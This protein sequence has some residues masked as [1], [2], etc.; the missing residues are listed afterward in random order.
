MQVIIR[1]GLKDI[2]QANTRALA[3]L[4][5]FPASGDRAPDVPSAPGKADLTSQ[6]VP[7][8]ASSPGRCTLCRRLQVEAW[9]GNIG[10]QKCRA[11]MLAQLAHLSSA[12]C[13]KRCS[14][15]L[16]SLATLWS[17]PSLWQWQWLRHP[18]WPRTPAVRQAAGHTLLHVLQLAGRRVLLAAASYG[19]ASAQGKC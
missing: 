3:A 1:I 19:S 4:Q 12:G 8:T 18:V 5:G 6:Q 2:S 17:C 15:V 7:M 13:S 11:L 10:R 16:Q 14:E 9:A